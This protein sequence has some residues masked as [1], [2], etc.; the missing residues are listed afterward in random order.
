MRDPEGIE[1]FK[2]WSDRFRMCAMLVVV[3][4]SKGNCVGC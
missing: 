2:G 4:E 1:V 3:L